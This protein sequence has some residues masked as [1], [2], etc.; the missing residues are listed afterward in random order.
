LL[1][2]DERARQTPVAPNGSPPSSASIPPPPIPDHELIRLI[3]RGSYGKVWL[4]RSALGTWRAVKIVHRQTFW[5]AHP[6]DR[7]FHGIEKFEPISR[8]HEGLVDILQVGR[9]DGFF[10]YVMELADEANAEC[11]ARNAESTLTRPSGTQRMGEG[12]GEGQTVPSSAFPVPSSYSPRTL[13]SELQ[14]R[15][16]LPAA[17]CLTT[18]LALTA[19]LEHLHQH[20]LVHRDVK[21]SNVIFVGGVPKLADIGMVAEV[22]EARSYV[23]TEGFIPPEG[24]GTPQADLYSLGKLLYEIST[25]KDRHEFPALPP[26]LDEL[27]DKQQLIEL[28]A[29]LLKACDPDPRRR[30]ASAASMRA[31][32]ELLQQ[33]GSIRRRRAAQHRFALARK[34]AL[35][36]MG[37]ALLGAFGY[38]LFAT[39][40]RPAPITPAKGPDRLSIFVLPFRHSAP[41]AEPSAVRISERNLC[42]CGRMTDA[43]IDALPLVS[44][45]QT[46]PRKS[47]WIRHD[48]EKVRH[49]L[50]RT[51]D[52]MYILSGRVEHTNERLRLELRLYERLKDEPFWS[53]TFEGTTNE[54]NGL[55]RRAI[56][57]VAR[58]LGREVGNLAG[59][60]IDQ[61]L[62]NNWAA[63]GLFLEGWAHHISGTKPGFLRALGYFNRAVE[64]D[65]KYV[66]A[67]EGWMRI[68]KELTLDRS[69]A[70]G[71]LD[72]ADRARRILE[73][74]DTSFMAH[75]RLADKL[76]GFDYDWE[77]GIAAQEQ[78]LALWPEENLRWVFFFRQVGRTNEARIYHERLKREPELDL[79][80]MQHLAMGEALWGNYGEAIRIANRMT[81]LAP[82]MPYFG[83]YHL[84]RTLLAAGRYAEAI[85]AFT[86]PT[87]VWE[88]PEVYGL[89]GWA[90]ALTGDRARALEMLRQLEAREAA[91]E[92]DPYYR[93]WI[94][95][96]LGD[97]DQALACLNK[98]IDYRSEYITNPDYGGLRTDP[99]WN[100]LREDP[101]FDDLCRRVGMG[102]DQWP[103]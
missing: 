75:L 7:E 53:Q 26:N 13:S 12:R 31:E 55:E 29:I 36:F 59:Q 21:P 50:V 74:D 98:A 73:I 101:R 47:D 56:Q 69:P 58:R 61:V 86:K 44:D 30:H 39:L 57:H 51:N 99:A 71:W 62:S 82:D 42:V 9:G 3:A 87:I 65:P 78:L 15:G 22:S 52:T 35:A 33:G 2:A 67:H 95:A 72:L 91:G 83:R 18:A 37:F 24:P 6:F 85:E 97:R 20:G 25:G 80:E 41:M 77:R 43:F 103:K 66:T 90:H 100:G 32:L 81:E 40:T 4:A 63:Y 79:F 84:G 1:G 10:Y 38:L 46:G 8:S 68:R 48:E 93:A 76:L 64:L 17:D 19:A 16:R 102:K 45:I 11:G 94:H 88:G 54:M 23:G 49:A 89:L 60:R 5:H 92:S 96:A 28:N 27:P 14:A 34:A 70:E